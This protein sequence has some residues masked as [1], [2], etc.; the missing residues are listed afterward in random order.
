MLRGVPVL[1]ADVGGI[2]EAMMGVDY[3]LPVRLIEKYRP[4]V[5]E[6]MVPVAEVPE[7]DVESWRRALHKLLA[8]KE[9]YEQLSALSR[10]RAHEYVESLS[11]GPFE[12]YLEDVRSRPARSRETSAP[13]TAPSGLERL[14]PEKRRLLALRL[15]KK[16]SDDRSAGAWFPAAE[17]R[18]GTLLRLFCFPCAGAG[19]A[20]YRGWADDLPAGAQVCPARLPGRE[21]RLNEVPFRQMEPLIEAL[22]KALLPHLDLPFA[23]FG[24]SMGAAIAFELTRA[25]RRTGRP[26]PKALFVSGARAPR[27]RLGHVPPPEPSE[28]DFLKELDR[29]DGLPGQVRESGDLLKI[30][31][32]ALR[33]DTALY[34]GYVYTEEPALTTPIRAYGGANDPNIRPEHLQAWA[35]ETTAEFTLR[36]FEGGHFFLETAR[37]EFLAALAADLR[38]ILA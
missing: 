20:A 17:A 27:F 3:L 8:S 38:G 22:D 5:D 21:N 24:H 6:Q 14:S 4:Q 28:E 33:A 12:A 18:P 30:V 34:R 36:F 31:L 7:Q 11:I 2:P 16:T 1:A 10:R 37:T 9:R 25:L 15:Q 32:P 29:L 19:A 13:A 35:Q 26:M 23:F